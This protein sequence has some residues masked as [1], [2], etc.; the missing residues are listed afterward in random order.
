M[1][2]I[3][4]MFSVALAVGAAFAATATP[5]V[6]G[7][8]PGAIFAQTAR[9][10]VTLTPATPGAQPTAL[11]AGETFAASGQVVTAPE[12][13]ATLLVLS[14]GDSVY[15]P[16]GGRMTLDEFTQDPV[17]DTGTSPDYEPSRSNVRLSLAEGTLLVSGRQ[18]NSTSTLT[19]L[20][21]L[22]RLDVHSHTFAVKVGANSVSLT[23]FD[24]TAVVTVTETGF[25]DIVQDGQTAVLSRQN[26]HADYPLKMADTTTA[27]HDT[28]TAWLTAARTAE[29]RVTFIGTPGKLQVRQHIP[30]DFFEQ[31]S[32]D[33]PRFHQ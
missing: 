21:P 30:R 1:K 24:G 25:H 26:L 2:R 3:I 14:N 15:L 22:A 13:L 9:V 18:P 10:G 8:G 32:T 20:T 16:L 5:D 17:T 7:A 19:I 6:G 28:F 12:D 27:D 23:L 4:A 11:T 29:R 33:D 31:M